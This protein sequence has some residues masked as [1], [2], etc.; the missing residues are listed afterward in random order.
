MSPFIYEDD[1]DY[2]VSVNNLPF[3]RE[4]LWN[5]EKGIVR[6]YGKDGNREKI[7]YVKYPKKYYNKYY[8]EH[9]I[10][11]KYENCPKCKFGDEIQ[12]EET[13]K[14]MD[15]YHNIKKKIVDNQKYIVATLSIIVILIIF[16]VFIY[17]WYQNRKG[18]IIE[19]S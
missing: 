7:N 8:L 13:S 1:N 12:E 15:N 9:K 2:I 16:G 5:K 17:R 14:F 10:L 11:P 3:H 19:E 6:I 18:D 4:E